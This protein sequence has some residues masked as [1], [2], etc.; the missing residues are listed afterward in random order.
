MGENKIDELSRRSINF[1]EKTKKSM[2]KYSQERQKLFK[3]LVDKDD[4]ENWEA[5]LIELEQ[6]V[7]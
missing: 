2:E 6:I 7:K 3:Y 1:L 5:Y 4:I